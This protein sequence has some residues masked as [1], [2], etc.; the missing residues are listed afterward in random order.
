MYTSR[1]N[2]IKFEDKNDLIKLL[3]F[4]HEQAAGKPELIFLP[5]IVQYLYFF[6]W[7][8]ASFV[9]FPNCFPE[10]FFVFDLNFKSSLLFH[11]L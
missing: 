2:G 11:Q 4:C 3:L 5:L 8:F 6:L 1:E 9:I 10:S 7:F